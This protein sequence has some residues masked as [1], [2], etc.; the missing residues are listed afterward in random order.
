M[1]RRRGSFSLKA[2]KKAKPPVANGAAGD[3][4]RGNAGVAQPVE[5]QLPKLRVASSNLVAR[6]NK[7]KDLSQKLQGPRSAREPQ[8]NAHGTGAVLG[9]NQPAAPRNGLDRGC[10]RASPLRHESEHALLTTAADST[11]RELFTVKQPRGC[12]SAPPS[13]RILSLAS[14]RPP[15]HGQGRIM[16]FPLVS[17]QFSPVN[18]Q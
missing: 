11:Q 5:H 10:E 1:R 16:R 17:R 2:A 8:R 7:I 6:S 13:P 14:N 4:V 3:N 12:A 15:P 18:S 9:V